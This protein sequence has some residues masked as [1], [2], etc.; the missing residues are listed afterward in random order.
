MGRGSPAA[1][2][3]GKISDTI[4]GVCHPKQEEFG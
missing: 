3:N 2:P 4:P 1:V